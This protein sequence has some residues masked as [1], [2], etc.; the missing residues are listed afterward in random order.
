MTQDAIPYDEFWL[1]NMVCMLQHYPNSAGVFGK[2]IAHDDA[3]FFTRM[4]IDNHFTHMENNPLSL[5][6][7][8]DPERYNNDIQWKQLLHYYSDNSSCLKKEVWEK[9]PYRDIKYGEDQVWAYDIIES[10]YQKLYCPSSIIKHSHDY[11][12]EETY[13]RSMIDSDYF[14]YFWG[15]EIVEKERADEIIKSIIEDE[16]RI[17]KKN[18]INQKALDNRKE[19][20]KSRVN[21][22]LSGL[23]QDISL[24]DKK[25][26]KEVNSKG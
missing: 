21:G 22:Y 10:G 23:A 15:Y 11:S 9:I 6:K 25:T 2:H 12:A 13:Q 26:K 4:E 24:F 8:L 17:G 14:K 7:S 3:T 20:I 18:G 19:I 1:Y 5:S 16:A